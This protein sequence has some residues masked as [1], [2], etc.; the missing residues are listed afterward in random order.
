MAVAF[1]ISFAASAVQAAE[2]APPEYTDLEKR[3]L[4]NVL[5]TLKRKVEPAPEGKR[6]RKIHVVVQEVFDESD[7]IPDFVNVFHATSR[8]YVIARELLFQEGDP[9][10]R[11][12][13]EE[14][15]RNLRAVRQLSL[16]L[17]VPLEAPAGTVDVLVIVRDVWSLRMNSDFQL[18]GTRLRDARGTEGGL[19]GL[20]R[21]TIEALT[22]LPFWGFRLEGT[23]VNYLFLNPSEENLF[24]THTNVGGLFV[25][26]PTSYS[27]GALVGNPRLLGTRVLGS[28]NANLIFNRQTGQ[29]EGS[30]GGIF[31]GQ[32]LY[33]TETRWAW[34]AGLQWRKDVFRGVEG[35]KLALVD[36]P[37]TE[38]VEQVPWQYRTFSL[39]SGSEVVRSYGRAVKLDVS[40]G[41]EANSTR[42]QPFGLGAVEPEPA[43][44]FVERVIPVGTSRV[45]PIF[46]L[47]SYLSEFTPRIEINSLGLQE[48]YRLGPEA[49]VRVFPAT[50]ALGSSRDLLGVFGGVAYTAPLGDGLARAVATTRL[51]LATRARN[52]VAYELATYAASPHVPFGRLHHSGFL[53]VR[54]QNYSNR[55]VVLGGDNR[56]RGFPS[57]AFV[58]SGAAVS[59][60]EFR[61]RSVDVLSAQV[62]A[63]TYYDVGAVFGGV[64]AIRHGSSL[65]VGARVLFPQVDRLVLRFDWAIPLGD[66][67]YPPTLP[68]ALFISFGQAFAVPGLSSPS[69]VGGFF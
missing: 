15:A 19:G 24:G 11:D 42:Y 66:P 21:D 44:K 6:V 55:G 63:A 22:P 18:E 37:D 59:N 38:A 50:E 7:P 68:G 2:V 35:G 36:F 48:D 41:A 46:Q 40:F 27:T 5:H 45:S 28:L 54:P 3:T 17:V 10:A 51:E 14:S 60:L 4:A 25:L 30:F 52:D 34:A 62:G 49:L 29:R 12:K 43:A 23:R 16:V 64:Q 8:P 13:V 31:A 57:G 33:S 58:G 1:A 61:T 53:L 47:R 9:F 39:A 26:T 65:G 56:L 67:R 20:A 69:L 32:P